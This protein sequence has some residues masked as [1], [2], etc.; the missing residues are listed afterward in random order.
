MKK[1]FRDQCIPMPS[2]AIL[3]WKTSNHTKK[4]IHCKVLM[5]HHALWLALFPDSERD[6]ILANCLPRLREGMVLMFVIFLQFAHVLVASLAICAAALR[7]PVFCHCTAGVLPDL[8]AFSVDLDTFVKDVWPSCT[9]RKFLTWSCIWT[10]LSDCEVVGC[11][12]RR[13]WL[14]WMLDS[15]IR[16]SR[17]RMEKDGKGYTNQGLVLCNWSL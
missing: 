17:G 8:E 3:I 1:A 5:I 15:R 4:R 14:A 11:I 10:L 6:A 12:W 2:G 13:R 16:F 7:V 9:C